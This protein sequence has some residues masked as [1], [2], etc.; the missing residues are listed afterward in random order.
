[1]E[2]KPEYIT[3]PITIEDERPN[4]GIIPNLS[5]EGQTAIPCDIIGCCDSPFEGTMLCVIAMIYDTYGAIPII[6]KD[7]SV[8][9]MMSEGKASQTLHALQNKKLIYTR[10]A[11]ENLEPTENADSCP[12]CNWPYGLLHRHH[13]IP[14]NKGGADTSDNITWL[15][16]NCHALAHATIYIPYWRYSH[17]EEI[18]EHQGN[19]L[20]MGT[21]N[22][23]ANETDLAP[24]PRRLRQQRRLL[25][26][27][28]RHHS[29][30]GPHQ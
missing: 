20:G 19:D 24:S 6:I 12:Y 4:M 23:Q 28:Y 5:N 8:L 2:P 22:L 27:Q 9:T 7:L 25:L 16:P 14:K 1:M 30:T 15:C 21:F 13:I 29:Q 18:N 11:L 26:A 17:N 10:A 3:D